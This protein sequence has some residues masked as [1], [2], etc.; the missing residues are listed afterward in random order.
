MRESQK[1]HMFPFFSTSHANF[2][3]YRGEAKVRLKAG[4]SAL[5]PRWPSTAKASLQYSCHTDEMASSVVTLHWSM[6]WQF[7]PT[8]AESINVHDLLAEGINE[9]F[10]SLFV[11]SVLFPATS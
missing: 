11:L 2:R 7:R 10:L 8:P 4:A 5:K 6:I 1:H 9:L 3:I